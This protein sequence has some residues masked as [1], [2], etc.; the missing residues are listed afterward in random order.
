MTSTSTSRRTPL[1]LWLEF[2]ASARPDSRNP[3]PVAAAAT[4]DVAVEARRA[5][6]ATGWDPHEVWLDRIKKPR[7]ERRAA[8]EQPIAVDEDITGSR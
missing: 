2:L 4:Y 3:A 6:A 8:S 7:D 1:Q 5:P